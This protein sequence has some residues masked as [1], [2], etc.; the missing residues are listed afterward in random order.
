MTVYSR[1]VPGLLLQEHVVSAPVDHARPDGPSLTVFARE[2][3]SVERVQD[4]LP[5]LLFLQGG[6]GGKSPRPL[7]RADWIDV[8]L[9]T[10]RVMLL[11]QR[12]TGRSTPIT[13]AIT[14]S[15]VAINGRII[16]PIRRHTDP[17]VIDRPSAIS[18]T[19]I[20]AMAGVNSDT[21]TSSPSETTSSGLPLVPSP[22]SP[23]AS[24]TGTTIT[25]I[26]PTIVQK[27]ER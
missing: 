5:W 15:M 8:A 16:R 25:A 27:W 2:V 23:R 4:D 17:I 1:P 6:P 9:R 26:D 3:R 10:H 14:I 7:Q 20:A 22:A 13:A 11:D 18:P 19:T 21:N 24:A 12:G